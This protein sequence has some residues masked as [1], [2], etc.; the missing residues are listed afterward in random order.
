MERIEQIE[1]QMLDLSKQMEA[2]SGGQYSAAV[3]LPEGMAMERLTPISS[4]GC[5]IS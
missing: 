1:E 3:A 4:P 5:G 2:G